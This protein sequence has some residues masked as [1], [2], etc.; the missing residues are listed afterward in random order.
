MEVLSDEGTYVVPSETACAR[1]HDAGRG[2]GRDWP[3][4]LERW[5]L[6]E[7]GMAAMAD[8]FCD[9]PPT[10]TEPERTSGVDD[11]A[12]GWLHGNCAFCHNPDGVVPAVSYVDIDWSY[13]ADSTGA[14]NQ[15]I[16]YYNDVNPFDRDNPLVID[17]GNPEE[18]MLITLVEEKDMPPLSV[19][20]HDAETVE[21]L[22]EW[23]R[24]ME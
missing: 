6:G 4:G 21:L 17:P 7:E 12:R 8:L 19:W 10:N 23:I 13:E 15:T 16:R 18:S 14:V 11:Q 20:T 5:Q 1:C 22:E 3:I 2:A 24:Q 9:D